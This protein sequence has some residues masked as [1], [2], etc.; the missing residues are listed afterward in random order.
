MFVH[1]LDYSIYKGLFC[2]LKTENITNFQ[3]Y[4]F[5]TY[6]VTFYV[7]MNVPNKL[8]IRGFKKKITTIEIIPK[9]NM[10]KAEINIIKIGE[11]H[12]VEVQALQ[13]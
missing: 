2:K 9:I 5:F 8:D 11:R 7:R 13:V 12:S 4:I 3:P 10:T 1:E 6:L